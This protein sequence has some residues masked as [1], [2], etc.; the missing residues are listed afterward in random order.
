M[1]LAGCADVAAVQQQPVVCPWNVVCGNVLHQFLFYL[2]GRVG[3]IADQADA[4]ADA[5]DVGID[6]HR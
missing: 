3:F 5:E 2:I 6:R 4:V 1:R